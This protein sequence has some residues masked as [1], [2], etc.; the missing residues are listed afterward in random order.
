MASLTDWTAGH[1]RSLFTHHLGGW[2]CF[3]DIAPIGEQTKLENGG[4]RKGPAFLFR[5]SSRSSSCAKGAGL[6]VAEGWFEGIKRVRSWLKPIRTPK[7]MSCNNSC[8]SHSPGGYIK[9]HPKCQFET[10]SYLPVEGEQIGRGLVPPTRLPNMGAFAVGTL[11]TGK[12][13]SRLSH[14]VCS[15]LVRRRRRL[16]LIK[17]HTVKCCGL[18][19]LLF[20]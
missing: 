7:L 9:R 6:A 11:V 12:L 14:K 8:T 4:A 2:E 20:L 17:A 16:F 1:E 3:F 18:I 10:G 13:L 5:D 19:L 15:R